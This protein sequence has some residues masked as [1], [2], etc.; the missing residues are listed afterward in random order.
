MLILYNVFL[1]L[2]VLVVRVYALFNN[3]AKKWIEGRKDWK[4][5][6]NN[7][8]GHDEKRIWIHCSS[9]GE[10]EQAKPLLE[11]IRVQY[12]AYKIVVTFFSPSGYEACKNTNLADY[13]FYLPHDNRRNAERFIATINPSVAMFVKYEFWYYYLTQLKKQRI[14]TLLISGAF[15]QEQPFFKWYGGLFREMLGCFSFYFLQDEASKKMLNA[16][17]F[18]KNILVS[19]DTRYDRVA[20]IA[21]NVTPI[22]AIEKF[23]G[24]HKILIAGSTWPGDENV[25]KDSM[26]V[27]PGNWKLIIVPHEVGEA[28]IRQVQQL[29]GSETILFSELDAENTGHDKKIL[30][31]DNIGMLSRL[32]AYANIAFIGGGFQKGGIHNILE[33]A[34]F[35]VPV[36]FGPIFEKFVEAKQLAALD[37]VFPVNGATD[38]KEILGKLIANEPYRLSVSDS[39]K[40]FMKDH[41]GASVVIMDEVERYKWLV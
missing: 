30:I 40:T 34:I 29:F 6:I 25:L 37:Y 5:H 18:H 19:G 9:M 2:Y 28:H 14:T 36:I 20:V 39:L 35:G 22:A 33:P 8:L 16:I 11:V 27:V 3:K 26:S 4:R 32:F 24:D 38:C 15:R 10:F 21:S 41:I 23:K 12:P 17:G 31:I 7:T 1:S 13:I